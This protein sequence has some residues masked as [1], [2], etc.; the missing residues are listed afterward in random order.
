M[1]IAMGKLTLSRSLRILILTLLSSFILSFIQVAALGTHG[2]VGLAYIPKAKTIEEK[3]SQVFRVQSAGIEV[4]VE[5]LSDSLVYPLERACKFTIPVRNMGGHETRIHPR[6]SEVPEGWICVGGGD[7]LLRPGEE[8]NLV[9]MFTALPPWP[10]PAVL[11]VTIENLAD[12]SSYITVN[13]RIEVEAISLTFDAEIKGRVI[14]GRTMNPLPGARV[15]VCYWSGYPCAETISLQDGSFSLM[16]PSAETL[17]ENYENHNVSGEPALYLEVLAEGYEYYSLSDIRVPRGETLNLEIGLISLRVEASYQLAW[18]QQVEGYEIWKCIPSEDWSLIAVCQ[19]EHGIE[20]LMTPP[21]HTYVYLFNGNG[22]LLWEKLIDGESWAVDI[23][24]DGSM[25]A[26][27]S[28]SGKVYVWSREG[29]LLWQLSSD[30]HGPIREVRFSHSGRYLAFGPTP[31]GRGYV[32]LYDAEIGELLWS[33]ETGDHVREIE[34]SLDDEYLVVSSTDGYTYLFTIEGQL[35]WKRYHGGY[36]PLILKISEGNDMI[37][38]GGKGQELYA[39]D[40]EGNLLWKFQAP[41]IIQCGD[42][43]PDLSRIVIES[44]G[45]LYML[46]REG[47]LLWRRSISPIGHNAIAISPDGHYIVVGSMDALRLYN[48]NGTV[49]WEYT[50]F[51]RG[52]P[53]YCEA[54]FLCAAQNVQISRGASMILAGFGETDRHLRLFIG[55]IQAVGEWP[56]GLGIQ[57]S[58]ET[59]K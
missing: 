29:G 16:V 34:F 3:F 55:S 59:A 48:S 13:L 46:D 28:H 7:L 32:G 40:F 56:T 23:T 20:G 12:P 8:E 33:Y 35:L 2:N 47:N 51:E 17:D 9:Y 18:K 57:T 50:D 38:V 19:G 10:D 31:E 37:V 14:D 53:P 43:T 1:G 27:G 39:Y 11:T 4:E 21:E 54:S 5:E 49:L 36:L 41:D 58:M 26:S 42:A 52:Q 30:M 24:A 15:R 22:Q 45:L 6:I 44:K 25:I